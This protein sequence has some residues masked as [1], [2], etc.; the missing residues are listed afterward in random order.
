MPKPKSRR[1]RWESA[2][3]DA[4]AS[5]QEL[6]DL[7]QEYQ[8]WADNLPENLEASPVGEKLEAVCELDIAGAM[9]TIEEADGTDLPLGF[10]RD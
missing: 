4:L 3:A 9:Q 7:Q 2:V 10:G 5:L 8:E 1:E 6:V